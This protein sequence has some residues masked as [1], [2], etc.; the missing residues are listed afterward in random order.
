MNR[1]G[2]SVPPLKTK[3]LA[4]VVKQFYNMA[5]DMRALLI[6]S[7]YNGLL[8]PANDIKLMGSVLGRKGFKLTECSG[9]NA[10]R[11]GIKSA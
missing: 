8:G 5:P 4:F 11:D 10:T 3:I 9:H 6:S 2:R 1:L 7:S